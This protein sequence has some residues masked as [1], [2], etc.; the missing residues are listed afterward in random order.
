MK[1][2]LTGDRPTGK[3]HIGH[4]I[5]SLGNRIKLQNEY[6]TF[7][8]VAD[9]Q[10]LTDRKDTAK[11][12]ENIIEITKDY[13]AAGIDPKKTTI[14]IQSHIPA[15]S[16]LYQI[17]SNVVTVSRVKRN[18]TVKEELKAAHIDEANMSLAMFSYP[19]S[20]AADILGF[21]A[22][23]VPVGEDQIPHIEQTREV[24]RT[25]NKTYGAVFP[26]PEAL[27]SPAPRIL[28]LDGK[29]KMSKSL[30]NTIMLSDTPDEIRS[31]FKKAVTDSGREIYFDKEHKP[32]ISN[33]LTIF[34]F[35]SAKKI[36]EL[37]K[38]FKEASY[39]EFKAAIAEELVDKLSELQKKRTEISESEVKEVLKKGTLKSAE[40]VND[41]LKEVRKTMQLDYPKIFGS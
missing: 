3:L 6:D 19:V 25:F 33:L 5:G 29:A 31:K 40:I 17:L 13:L 35:F 24:A 41:T 1:R 27:L 28:G 8:I 7:I 9:F 36:S 23:L 15:L 20:Q 21:K 37:E 18:P 26:E 10:V 22:N 32:E 11:I 16:E 12:E 39:S 30:G 34:S 2:I 38:E 14:F 4:L